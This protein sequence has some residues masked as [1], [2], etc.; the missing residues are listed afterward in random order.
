MDVKYDM[1]AK[2]DCPLIYIMSAKALSR[3][4]T[5]HPSLNDLILIRNR[6]AHLTGHS[7]PP[8]DILD[9]NTL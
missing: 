4:N 6:L 1:K 8:P 9:P 3:S 7:P 5:G 2:D